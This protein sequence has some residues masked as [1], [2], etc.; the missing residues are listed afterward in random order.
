MRGETS[1]LG[2]AWKEKQVN[3][4]KH[5]MRNM[6]IRMRMR[7]ETSKLGWAWQEKQVN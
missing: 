7:G 3:K 4:D 1:K 2:W 5:E 6:K